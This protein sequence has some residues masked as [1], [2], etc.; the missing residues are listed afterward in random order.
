M[1]E[2]CVFISMYPEARGG[3]FVF[4]FTHCFIP[5]RHGPSVSQKL[6]VSP[7][8]VR[9]GAH[10][11]HLLCSPNTA[12]TGILSYTWFLQGCWGLECSAPG[13]H[14]KL[15]LSTPLLQP[16]YQVFSDRVWHWMWNSLFQSDSGW[17]AALRSCLPLRLISCEP[18]LGWQK[19]PS[20]FTW[21]ISKLESY[22]LRSKLFT[23]RAISP[24]PETPYI[25]L[26]IDF[27]QNPHE[28][29]FFDGI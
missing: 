29:Q 7:R 24:G 1:D 13:L 28:R 3:R 14:N 4:L 2:C 11:M 12:V 19:Q 8:L 17:Q 23:H 5:L 6:A 16:L 22:C 9:K 26:K 15:L 25:L 21:W 18:Q 27:S 20:A 10:T